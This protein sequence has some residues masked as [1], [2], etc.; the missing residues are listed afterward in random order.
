MFCIQNSTCGTV[1]WFIFHCI[2]YRWVSF[3]ESLTNLDIDTPCMYFFTQ[4]TV[5]ETFNLCKV[6]S[7][8]FSLNGVELSLNSVNSENLRNHWSTNW[9]Q[10]KDLLCYLC[11]YGLVVS[12]LSLTQEILGS[13]PQCSFLI[14]LIFILS[15]NSRNSVKTFRENSN[16]E[17]CLGVLSLPWFWRLWFSLGNASYHRFS[18][19]SILQPTESICLSYRI[20]QQDNPRGSNHSLRSQWYSTMRSLRNGALE[21]KCYAVDPF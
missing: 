17:A 1:L 19:I 18:A 16:R 20:R 6:L 5:F 4:A 11:L 8:E 10:Y 21:V 9:V 12:S 13:T 15:L 7:M 14:F 2:L 3:L